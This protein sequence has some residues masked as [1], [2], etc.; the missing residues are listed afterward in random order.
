M[1]R[2]FFRC[3][4]CGKD[5]EADVGPDDRSTTTDRGWVAFLAVYWPP[6]VAVGPLVLRI[7]GGCFLAALVRS[8]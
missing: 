2:A 5:G 1:P 6:G 3:V 4:I 7:C 8:H